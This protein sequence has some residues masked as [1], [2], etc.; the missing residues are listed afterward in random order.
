MDFLQKTVCQRLF[1]ILLLTWF[2]VCF[3]NL[4]KNPVIFLSIQKNYRVGGSWVRWKVNV[5]LLDWDINLSIATSFSKVKV[6][7]FLVTCLSSQVV[8]FVC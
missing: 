2:A 7:S 1:R 8:P 6:T 4:K 3:F 5:V